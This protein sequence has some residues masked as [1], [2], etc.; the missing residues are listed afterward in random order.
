[1]NNLRKK[2]IF[3]IETLRMSKT[4]SNTKAQKMAVDDVDTSDDDYVDPEMDKYFAK[5]GGESKI[6]NAVNGK[7]GIWD[8]KE[9]DD[10]DLS[11][12]EEEEAEDSSEEE[13]DEENGE[14]EKNG[15]GEAE[16]EEEADND[17]SDGRKKLTMNLIKKWSNDL[18]V[19]YLKLILF[20][21]L[22]I[23]R[24]LKS[25]FLIYFEIERK[26]I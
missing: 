15:G 26:T 23:R 8:D 25:F 5:K 4:K 19:L 10:E 12:Y 16:E 13:D 11:E 18:G 21:S 22:I 17:R 7:S 1:M 24:S 6:K 14:N 9:E 2:N 3:F 20:Y